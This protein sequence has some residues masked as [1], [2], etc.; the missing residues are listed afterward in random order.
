MMRPDDEGLYDENG[1]LAFVMGEEPKAPDM[2]D[3]S[4][5]WYLNGDN[6]D[7]YYELKADSYNK[8]EADGYELRHRYS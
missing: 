4:G 3:I 1:V 5:K 2:S 7:E 6:S 8:I